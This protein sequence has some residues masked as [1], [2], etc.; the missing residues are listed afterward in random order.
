MIYHHVDIVVKGLIIHLSIGS[1]AVPIY[2]VLPELQCLWA[3]QPF[4]M[5]TFVWRKRYPPILGTGL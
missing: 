3:N 1:N 4:L 2:L 5:V